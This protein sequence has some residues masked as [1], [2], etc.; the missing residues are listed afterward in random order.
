MLVI[1]GALAAGSMVKA[2]LSGG[3]GFKI[4][5]NT[6]VVGTIE[7]DELSPSFSV[8]GGAD[9]ALFKIG[10]SS[11]ILEFKTAPN[12][13]M[14]GDTGKENEYQVEVEDGTGQFLAVTV[15]VTDVN[16]APVFTSTETVSAKENQTSSGYQAATTDEEANSVSYS[17]TGSDDDSLLD[18]NAST[19]VLA[20]RE[21][22]NFESPMDANSDNEYVV[23]VNANDGTNDTPQTVKITV[24]DEND[25][26]KFTSSSTPSAKE[27][28]TVVTTVVGTDED[29]PANTLTYSIKT[30]SDGAFFKVDPSTG[31]LTFKVAPN[32]EDPK[33]ENQ[34]NGYVLNVKV[35]DGKATSIQEITVAV[36]D[37]N[38]APTITSGATSSA[39]E[40]QTSTEYSVIG[41]DVDANTTLTYSIDGGDDASLLE[42]NPSTGA[43]TFKSAPDFENPSD[44]NVDN[45]Y[46]VTVKVSD[47]EL[48]ATKLITVTVTD[49]NGPV[50]TSGG[51]GTAVEAQTSTSYTA[52]AN[53]DDSN[54][55][56]FSISGGSESAL[57]EIDDTTGVLSFKADPDFDI[58]GDANKDNVYEVTIQAASSGKT[59]TKDVEISVTGVNEFAPVFPLNPASFD[60]FENGKSLVGATVSATDGDAGETVTY[61]LV[62]SD[63]DSMFD[64]NS[65]TGVV[66]FRS[67]PDF[68]NP[69]D[70]D[71]DGSYLF[72]VQAG[73]NNGKSTNKTFT[74]FVLNEAAPANLTFTPTFGGFQVRFDAPATINIRYY[75]VEVKIDGDWYSQL[76]LTNRTVFGGLDG[77]RSYEV[78]IAAQANEDLGLFATGEVTTLTLP[79][80][81]AGPKGD[82]GV[83]GP[84]GA[85]GPA[86]PKGDTGPA[87]VLVGFNGNS[88]RI[89]S[90]SV[91]ALRAQVKKSGAQVTVYGYQ[92]GT[93]TGRNSA[94][95]KRA[96]AV[97]QQ[98]LK[99]D[100]KLKVKV[101]VSKSGKPA[102]CKSVDNRCAIVVFS[103]K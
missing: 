58:P 26:P 9:S 34:D 80:G 102:L 93:A 7:S 64:I 81:P 67:M 69:S 37:E 47:G 86:G 83:A 28:Q 65:G 12:F 3:P 75:T 54:P 11:G 33:D 31:A 57:L 62:G 20:F 84:A 43:L 22:P 70:G 36:T 16:E 90:A 48:T 72:T 66:T 76:T 13:E 79:S 42:V 59:I 94:A 32:F 88:V 5:E 61:A 2:A 50:F 78:R 41:S 38:E 15:R 21:S 77:S 46:E 71:G 97:K 40:N 17:L 91:S 51:S 39:S 24:T 96:N 1:S 89:N 98:L 29:V 85:A 100:P 60:Y 56:V 52:V 99:L 73:D 18:I 44:A 82:A 30:G 14:P 92:T 74:I 10:I 19:G 25:E 101:V 8:T 4:K 53:D 63:D 103:K 45:E 95:Y 49:V 23:T 35:D 68:E 87:G 55:V 27:N 6:T